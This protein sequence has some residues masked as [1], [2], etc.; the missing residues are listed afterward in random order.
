MRNRQLVFALVVAAVSIVAGYALYLGSGPLTA[1]IRTAVIVLSAFAIVAETLAYLLPHGARASI[2]FIPY[3]ASA[4]IAP[5]WTS[6]LAVAIVAL[7]IQLTQRIRI[8]AAV[9]N[10]AQQALT[11]TVAILAYQ[12]LGGQSFLATPLH[13][14][15]AA[16]TKSMGLAALSAYALS[17]AVNNLVVSMF[18]AIGDGESTLN[19]WRELKLS[20]IG[21]DL[22]ASPIVF[23]FAWLYAAHGAMAAAI[24]WVP[25]VGLRELHRTNL[26]LERTNQELLEL[27]VKSIEARDPYT[28]GHSRRVEQ[29]STTI[30]RAL[31]LPAREIARVSRAALLHDVGK[32]Y[33]KYGSLLSKADRLSNSEWRIMQEHPVDGAN[34]VAT[35]TRLRELVESIRHHHENWDGSGYPDAL[36]GD[37]IPIAARIIRFADTIDAMTTQ[38]P[39]RAALSEEQVRQEVVRCR[40]TQ[41]DPN[42]ADRL[43]GSSLWTSLFSPPVHDLP[44]HVRGRP[45]LSVSS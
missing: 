28:S 26:E 16:L 13:D 31:G 21:F 43:L 32:I 7:L 17:F 36:S 4:L 33:E 9:L 20:T 23:L 40:G 22:L 19:V 34:L 41:F 37:A 2:G 3:L 12:G 42:I 27:M 29:Y 39:Y 6:V 8:E 24:I 35:M 1:E 45:T 38:R 14:N 25:M 11:L 30:A 15:F 18:I 10:V 44:G 5:H